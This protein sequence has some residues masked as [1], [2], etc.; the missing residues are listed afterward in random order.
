MKHV[1]PATA[2]DEFIR[3]NIRVKAGDPY[4]T[5]AVDDDVRSLYAT[6]LFYNIQ[7]TQQTTPDGV[8][9]T[10][11]LQGKPRRD[12]NKIPGQLDLQ[13]TETPEKLTSSVGEPLDER[14]LFTDSQAI[15]QMYQKAGYPGTQVKYVLSIDENAGRGTATFEITESRRIRI[16][17][18]EF[19]GANAFPEKTLRGEIKTRRHWMFSWITGSG[20]FK[21]DQFDDDKELL[22]EFYRNKGYIDF[23]IKEVQFEHPTPKTMVIVFMIYEGRQYKVVRSNSPATSSSASRISPPGCAACS[24]PVSSPRPPSSARTD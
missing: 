22:A 11:V 2:N 12:G 13:G 6:G 20:V 3:A 8:V 15:Q 16:T 19:V 9:L 7:V 24:R 5:A 18:V 10:Y 1:G 4:R 21:D 17:D 14:K 23:E